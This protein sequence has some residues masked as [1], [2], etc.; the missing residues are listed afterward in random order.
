[1]ETLYVFFEVGNVLLDIIQM[2]FIIQRV[3]E[4]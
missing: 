1:M 4:L 2:S 3:K